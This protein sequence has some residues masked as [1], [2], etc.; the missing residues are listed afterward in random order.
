MLL[1]LVFVLFSGHLSAQVLGCTDALSKNYIP[2]ASSNDGSCCY[3][4]KSIRPYSSVLL[5]E[6]LHETS[7]LLFW[8]G[9]L[10]THNDDTDTN[11][12]ALDTI[13]GKI[14]KKIKLNHVDNTD[15][16]EIAQDSAFIYIGDFG[17]NYKGNRNDLKV[18]R[19]EKKSLL[20]N[21]PKID[22]IAFQYPNQTDLKLQHSNR[23]NFDCE[24]MIVTNDSLYLFTKEWKSKKTSL[25]ALPK[26]PGTY[27]ANYRAVLNVKGLITGATY[28][29]NQKLIALCGYSKKLKPFIYLL[30]DFEDNDFFLGNRRKI[31]L[32][33]PFHQIEGI[34]TNDGL[35]Y[36]V[37]N[38][39]FTRKPIIAVPQKLHLLDLSI[40]LQAYLSAFKKL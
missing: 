20:L 11:L 40:Y 4:K 39:N 25:F 24:A 23:T 8:D 10:W 13:S 32:K 9:F 5:N 30:Y 37:S 19:V 29:K 28:L 35:H 33:L 12:Y 27:V 38:E 31:K 2:L 14:I 15:W 36:Y 22:T 1:L 26:T 18:L 17:N 34:T 6:Q 16:E 3:P 21:Q 7:G